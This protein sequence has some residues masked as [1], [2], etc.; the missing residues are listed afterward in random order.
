MSISLL[1]NKIIFKAI[2]LQLFHILLDYITN[3]GKKKMAPYQEVS[4][5]FSKSR[6]ECDLV[7]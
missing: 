3:T 1:R 7:M 5:N 4:W 2:S 6:S